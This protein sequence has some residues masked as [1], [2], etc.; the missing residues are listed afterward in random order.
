MLIMLLLLLMLLLP[1]DVDSDDDDVVIIAD[2]DDGYDVD[3]IGA[4]DDCDNDG[5]DDDGK[6]AFVDYVG[7]I[8]VMRISM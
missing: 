7:Y 4:D 2:Y 5:N 3:A 8:I 1:N 6:A